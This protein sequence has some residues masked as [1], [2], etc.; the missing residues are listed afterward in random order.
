M[1]SGDC[2]K[3]VEIFGYGVIIRRTGKKKQKG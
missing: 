3:S 1:Q 2:G